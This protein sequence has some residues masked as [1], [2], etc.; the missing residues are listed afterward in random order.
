M[1]NQKPNRNQGDQKQKNEMH[2]KTCFIDLVHAR[3]HGIV[4]GHFPVGHQ[5]Q[6]IKPPGGEDQAGKYQQCEADKNYEQNKKIGK[7][8]AELFESN[9]NIVKGGPLVLPEIQYDQKKIAAQQWAGNE[10]DKTLGQKEQEL[11]EE[12]AA[13][14][15]ERFLFHDFPGVFKVRL[16]IHGGSAG[17]KSN[18]D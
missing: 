1:E 14:E 12:A 13:D 15:D 11:V 18:T 9:K 6:D 7:E 2:E 16:E 3:P 4:E 10:D 8:I 17:H 5:G